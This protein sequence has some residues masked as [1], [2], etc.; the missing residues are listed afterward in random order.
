M[1]SKMIL[2]SN[3][4]LVEQGKEMLTFAGE[5]F[6][7]SDNSS[8]TLDLCIKFAVRGDRCVAISPVLRQ[9]QPIKNLARRSGNR[10]L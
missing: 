5:H 2:P 9:F 7:F 8:S 10:H 1:P 3:I 6:R 4:T